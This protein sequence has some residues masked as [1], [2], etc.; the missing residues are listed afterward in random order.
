MKLKCEDRIRLNELGKHFDRS[1]R[2]D[3]NTINLNPQNTLAHERLKSEICL[4]LMYDIKT[5]FYTEVTFKGGYRADVFCPLY[6]KGTIIEV[7]HSET[8]KMSQAKKSK[9]PEELQNLTFIY[10][11]TK[12][13]FKLRF[14]Q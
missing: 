10:V 8:E 9:L 3:I 14:I 13:K 6:L 1:C 11:E 5:P 2:I 4:A 7:R 12:N